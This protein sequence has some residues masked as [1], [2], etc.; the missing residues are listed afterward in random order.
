MKKLSSPLELDPTISLLREVSPY[1][2]SHRA[3]KFVV[4]LDGGTILSDSF[5]GLARDLILLSA[6]GIRI[7]VVFGANQQI[8]ERLEAKGITTATV[9]DRIVMDRECMVEASEVIGAM[10][11][12]IESNFSF[13]SRA[14][15]LRGSDATK[16]SSG[17]FVTA[18]ACGVLEGVDTLFCGEVRSLDITGIESRLNSGDVVLVSPIGYSPVGEIFDIKGSDLAVEIA[19]SIKAEKLIFLTECD[20]VFGT[21]GMLLKQLGT[22]L[23]ASL[24]ASGVNCSYTEELL[25]AAIR[26]CESGVPRAHFI[27]SQSDGAILKELFTRDGVGTMLSDAPFDSIRTAAGRDILGILELIRPMQESGALVG[28]S[29]DLV[30]KDIDNFIVMIREDTVVACAALYLHD[31]TDGEVAC[32]AVHEDYR[33]DDF[34]DLL[35]MEI[36]KRALEQQRSNLFVMTTQASH[37]FQERGYSLC[38]KGDLPHQKQIEYDSSRNSI[39]LKKSISN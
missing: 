17:N 20:G 39:V 6:V 23:G 31:E 13:V 26:A 14:G 10:R 28:R 29:F 5:R 25:G 21:D 1:F 34:G 24:L 32:V 8:A 18:K 22:E 19:Q 4:Y 27:D 30:G 7:T 11:L 12:A 35:L 33:G 2:L 15:A 38:E 37:W 16:V 9:A 3:K 36:E